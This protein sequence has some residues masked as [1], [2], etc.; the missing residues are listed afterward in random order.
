[1]VVKIDSYV[2]SL[3]LA[4]VDYV[5]DDVDVEL[6]GFDLVAVGFGL[7]HYHSQWLRPDF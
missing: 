6:N 5:D 4:A 2:E 3:F 7:F 1:M